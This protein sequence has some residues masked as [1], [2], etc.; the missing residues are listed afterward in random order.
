[1][2]GRSEVAAGAAVTTPPRLLQP[3]HLEPSKDIVQSARSA[4]TANTSIVAGEPDVT[5]GADRRMPPSE[6]HGHHVAPSK[7]LVHN[8]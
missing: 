7:C 2:P 1:V 5:A 8:A 6:V 3:L 4:P